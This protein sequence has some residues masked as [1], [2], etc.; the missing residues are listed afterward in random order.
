MLAALAWYFLKKKGD[1]TARAAA[2]A[3]S[4]E[5]GQDIF[6]QLSGGLDQ[7]LGRGKQNT[8]GIAGAST[9][10]A[11]TTVG[12]GSGS[13]TQL[14]GAAINVNGLIKG[15]GS[16]IASGWKFISTRVTGSLNKRYDEPATF[17]QLVDAN[18]PI[19]FS[20]LA[21]IE[22][23]NAVRDEKNFNDLNPSGFDYNPDPFSDF[24]AFDSY[25]A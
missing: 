19:S 24:G 21:G 13:G 10:R 22:G 17:D 5:G 2:N 11:A 9:G 6:A 25:Y 18:T 7:L 20:D 16:A 23:N 14:S 8:A 3:P 4:S 1:A 15:L 12:S